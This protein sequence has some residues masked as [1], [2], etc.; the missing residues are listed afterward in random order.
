M[1]L[2]PIDDSF[3]REVRGLNLWESLSGGHGDALREAFSEHPVLVFRR[4]ALS[5]DELLGFGQV[6]GEPVAYVEK[7]WWSTRPEISVVSN[8]LDGAGNPIGGLSSRELNWHTDQS[9]NPRPITGCLLYAQEVPGQ[10]NRTSWANLYGAWDSLPDRWR[11]RLDGALGQ[12]SYAARTRHVIRD[13]EADEDTLL[14]SY[15]ER[16]R[17]TPDVKHAMVN[18][19]PRSERRSVYMDPGTLIGVDGLD[20]EECEVL[21]DLL[22]SCATR[23]DNVY[24]HHWRVG[25]LVLWDNAV[26]L[27]RRDAFP[28]DQG[29]LMKRMLID[30]PESHH[31]RPAAH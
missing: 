10:G 1:D 27:H 23:E 8:L 2:I 3:A 18:T 11:T 4:Q 12:F 25:D 15:A 26:T 24:H 14:Q 21:F 19:H 17:N 29:R 20:A 5:E 30:L 13:A 28:D 16:T 22:E 6:L 7:S 31:I 9:Y